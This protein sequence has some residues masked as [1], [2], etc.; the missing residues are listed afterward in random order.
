MEPSDGGTRDC[1]LPSEGSIL[2]FLPGMQEI[3]TLLDN[4]ASH[5]RIGRSGKFL[6][7][8]LHSSLS[9]EEQQL[10]FSKPRGGQR[11]IVISTNMA[12]TSITIDDCV[13]VIDVGRMKEKRFDPTKN[14]ESLDTVW[15]SRANALQRRGRAGRV[16]EGYAFHLYTQF[17]YDNH[18]RPDPVPEIQRVPLEKMV[19][20]IKILP[21]FKGSSVRAVLAK[22]LEPPGTDG[23]ETALTRLQ[24]VG[25]LYPDNSLTP[26][27]YHLAQLPVDVRIGKLMLFGAIF[28]CLDAALTIAAS[29]SY[30]TPFLSPFKEREAANKARLRW[31]YHLF[32]PQI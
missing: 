25:A 14:M 21:A 8:P 18:M 13:F 11:K 23:V 16:M 27:G 22:V 20:R 3:M 12:E 1:P 9:S 31:K 30:R 2:V 15:V 10:V 17:R 5:P 29:L 4:L 32:R 6:L 7:V 24:G 26:L 28:R 19:L